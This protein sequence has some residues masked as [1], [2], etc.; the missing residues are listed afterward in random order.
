MEKFLEKLGIKSYDDFLNFCN[1]ADKPLALNLQ[2]EKPEEWNM[3]EF[4]KFAIKFRDD[5]ELELNYICYVCEHCDAM[6]VVFEIDEP[7]FNEWECEDE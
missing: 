6:H 7:T 3:D 1:M 4:R 2:L 5:T